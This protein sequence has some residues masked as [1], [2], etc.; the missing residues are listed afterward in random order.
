MNNHI[1]SLIHSAINKNVISL[2]PVSGGSI[3]STFRAELDD[4][5]SLFIKVSPQYND[6]FIK[7]ASGFRELKK[8]D[9][10]RVPEVLY[11][12]EEILITEFL[13][14]SSPTHRTQFFETFGS[15]FARLHRQT[16]DTFGF[17]ENNYIGSTPQINLPQMRSWKEF[18]ILN[19]LDFQFRLA[20]KNG[21]NDKEFV[22]LFRSLEKQIIRLI[23]EDGEPPALLHGDLW[24]GNYLCTEKNIPAII[25]PAVYYGHREADLAMTML[26]GGF[27]EK[28]YTAYN[29]EYPLNE[30]WERR[31]ELYKLYHLFNHLNLFGVGFYSQVCETMKLLLK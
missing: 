31:M 3:A 19:R 29:Q 5:S 14:V 21:H 4:K 13:P 23:P 10:I 9:A 28:F 7:E 17:H 2:S 24:S 12:S 20:E 1:H 8:A 16:S 27:G 18:F 25:D 30:G 26:F 15:Q 22:S 11:A 6:M